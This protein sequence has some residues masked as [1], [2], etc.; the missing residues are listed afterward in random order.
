MFKKVIGKKCQVPTNPACPLHGQ[1]Q[2]RGFS[3]CPECAGELTPVYQVDW[4]KTLIVYGTCLLVL[5]AGTVFGVGTVGEGFSPAQ[6]LKWASGLLWRTNRVGIPDQQWFYGRVVWNFNGGNPKGYSQ[7][8]QLLCERKGGEYWFRP[9]F[10]SSSGDR[11]HFEL[12]PQQGYVYMFSRE[13]A[14]AFPMYPK[15]QMPGGGGAV[16]RVPQAQDMQLGGGQATEV[17]LIVAAKRPIQR[18]V[19]LQAGEFPP[20]KLDEVARGLSTDKDCLVMFV[21]I[22]H[23]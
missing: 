14:K 21:Q 3:I 11:V 20:A 15:D 10:T 9:R 22:P 12:Y 16:I 17:F 7:T 2:D 4:P 18:L 13:D 6:T 8:D 19:E 23:V 1:M 5:G